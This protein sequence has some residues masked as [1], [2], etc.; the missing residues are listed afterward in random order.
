MS[1]KGS[2]NHH[3]TMAVQDHETKVIGDRTGLQDRRVQVVVLELQALRTTP[4]L[5]K[6]WSA[7]VVFY[8][9]PGSLLRNAEW[10]RT[11]ARRD[12]TLTVAMVKEDEV[13][14]DGVHVRQRWRQFQV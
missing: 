2:Q 5:H 8:Y 3:V 9:P 10:H 6:H 1:M 13:A 4:S 7:R 12:P 14:I 11:C